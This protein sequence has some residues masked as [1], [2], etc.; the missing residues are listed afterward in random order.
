M[1]QGS[2]SNHL[3]LC[4]LGIRYLNPPKCIILMVHSGLAIHPTKEIPTKSRHTECAVCLV[5]HLKIYLDYFNV[6]CFDIS[7]FALAFY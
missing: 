6:F 4:L 7:E 2:L 1:A 5:Q 3:V